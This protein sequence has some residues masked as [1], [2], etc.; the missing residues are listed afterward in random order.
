MNIALSH[1][2]FGFVLKRGDSM[3][4]GSHFLAAPTLNELGCVGSRPQ[5]QKKGIK[6]PQ[7]VDGDTSHLSN[8]RAYSQASVSS[9]DI[10]HGWR[11]NANKK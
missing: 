10:R 1:G 6:P 2:G 8:A 4:R 9:K 11:P 5:Q 3:T 7:S